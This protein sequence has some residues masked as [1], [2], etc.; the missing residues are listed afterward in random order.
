MEYGEPSSELI[1]Y[2]Q[3]ATL[4]SFVV[5]LLCR[6][7]EKYAY[8]KSA[9]SS[10]LSSQN[11]QYLSLSACSCLMQYIEFIASI[12]FAPRSLKVNGGPSHGTRR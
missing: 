8:D 12:T 1:Y 2:A 4:T 5:L 3:P 10:A 9:L 11:S 6:L 7:I